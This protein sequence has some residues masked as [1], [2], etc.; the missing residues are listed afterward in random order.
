MTRYRRQRQSLGGRIASSIDRRIG[1]ALQK[2]VQ[3]N[4]P[5]FDDDPGRSQVEGV[6]I[7][8]P[9]GGM[10]H[11]IG[12][13]SDLP[14][15]RQGAHA[16]AVARPLDCL[17]RRAGLNLDADFRKL[18]HEPAHELGIKARKHALR[19]LQYGHLCTR[20]RG[21]MGELGRDVAATDHDDPLRQILKLHECIAEDGVLR[22][23]EAERDRARASGNHD[24]TAFERAAFHYDRVRTIETG[25]PVEGINALFGKTLFT[26]LRYGI[27]E[28]PLEGDHLFPVDAR[29]A[30][31]FALMHPARPIGRFGPA[32]QH[33]LGIAAAQSASSA[34]GTMVNYR[35]RLARAADA[36]GNHL[37]AG[38]GADDNDVV[39]VHLYRSRRCLRYRANPANPAQRISAGRSSL[40][41]LASQAVSPTVPIAATTT[42]AAQQTAATAATTPAAMKLRSRMAFSSSARKDSPRLSSPSRAHPPLPCCRRR[43]PRP[44]Y[45]RMTRR[46]W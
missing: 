44:S 3:D 19:S 26:F 2:F 33:F 20:A 9:A 4:S 12:V 38:A 36:R 13:N 17:D 16:E 22:T 40:P 42:G 46:H 11:E 23:V 7:G 39:A 21:D 35:N 14:A 28:G 34:E 18:L 29:F 25:N 45:L 5:V 41:A 1:E 15:L 8:C 27:G 43:L 32:D 10:N 24:V 30:N 31:D 6:E 37:R